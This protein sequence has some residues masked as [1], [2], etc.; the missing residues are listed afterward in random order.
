MVEAVARDAGWVVFCQARQDSDQN[1]E[2]RTGVGHSGKLE[3]DRLTRF[4]AIE[5]GEGEAIAALAASDPTGRWLVIQRDGGPLILFDSLT[6]KETEL[7][8]VDARNDRLP[9]SP[10]RSLSFDASGSELLYL[11]SREGKALS[12]VRSLPNGSEHAIDP[13]A[14]NVWRAELDTSGSWAM[15]RSLPDGST[16]KSWPAPP[17]NEAP[18]CR[19]PVEHYSAW[20]GNG[21]QPT[22]RLAKI[23]DDV[24]TEVPGFVIPFGR[25]WVIRESDGRLLL[26]QDGKDT[27][28]ASAKCGARILHAD[29][30]RQRL[31]VACTAPKGRPG[32]E[33]VG[34][35]TRIDLGVDVA[36]ASDDRAPDEPTRLFALYPGAT[37]ALVDLEKGKL[38]PLE[39]G[40]IVVTTHEALALVR[41][42]RKLVVVDASQRSERELEVETDP[43]PDT[44][45]SH[46]VAVVSPWVVDLERAKPLLGRVKGR[47]LAV[48]PDGRVL[49]AQTSDGDVDSLASG[50]LAWR[51]PAN[52]P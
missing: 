34:V 48:S 25:A 47:A 46:G 16:S 41:R 33:I 15:F 22:W 26:R 39:D 43:L 1:G 7:P 40:D 18:Q 10:H 4:L 31:I 14:E 13:G 29:A 27:E 12:I 11:T 32:V 38:V 30:M 6:H 24:A 28:V 51:V 52:G 8:G 37:T 45:E 35:G 44:F 42:G 5:S 50:P 49:V 9:F 3:G 20:Q 21:T 23:A 2:L 36:L 19:S 17:A